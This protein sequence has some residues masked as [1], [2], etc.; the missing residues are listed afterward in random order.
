MIRTNERSGEAGDWISSISESGTFLRTS[1]TLQWLIFQFGSMT[2]FSYSSL[3]ILEWGR[4]IAIGAAALPRF[5]RNPRSRLFRLALVQTVLVVVCAAP[6]LLEAQAASGTQ[7]C[8]GN[9]TVDI[10]GAKTAMSARAFLA[11]LQAAVQSNNKEQIEGMISYPLLVLRSGKRTRIRQKQAFLASYGQI[12]T[13]PI[14]DA[15]LHQTA[16]CLFGNSSGAMAGSG[17]VWF[18]EQAPGQ[19]KI[20]TINESASQP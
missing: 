4:E 6:G 10:L 13:T 14:R 19:W 17:E 7:A 3:K 1:E 9:S 2:R 11:Q 15:I 18:R 8:G 5:D 20:I 16:Q 12:F